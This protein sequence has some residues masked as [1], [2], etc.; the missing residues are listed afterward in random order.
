MAVSYSIKL[1]PEMGFRDANAGTPFPT[2]IIARHTTHST[3]RL[4]CR[5]H[6]RIIAR[7]PGIIE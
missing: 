6:A 1:A 3:S 7:P 2:E 4:S 5:A